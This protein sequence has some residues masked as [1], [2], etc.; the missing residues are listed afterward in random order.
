ML[1]KM[2]NIRVAIRILESPTLGKNT[3]AVFPDLKCPYGIKMRCYSIKRSWVSYSQDR[4]MKICDFNLCEED[5]RGKTR[6]PISDEEKAECAFIRD[7]VSEKFK[8]M[9]K[10]TLI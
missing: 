7:E 1:P 8:Y 9:G 4:V 3:V 10:I 6:Q 2:E 5:L